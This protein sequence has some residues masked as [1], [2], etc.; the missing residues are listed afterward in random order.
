MRKIGYLLCPEYARAY[1]DVVLTFPP[2]TIRKG[3]YFE[4]IDLYNIAI[5]GGFVDEHIY[6]VE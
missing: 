2:G 4:R 1:L 3:Y 6:G 5:T